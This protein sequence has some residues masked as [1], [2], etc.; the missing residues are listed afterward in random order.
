MLCHHLSF[1]SQVLKE[2]FLLPLF[3]CVVSVQ[4]NIKEKAIRKVHVVS[5]SDLRLNDVM[6][7]CWK[8]LY[9][10]DVDDYVADSSQSVSQSFSIDDS[11][12]FDESSQDLTID[13]MSSMDVFDSYKPK[14]K[15]NR[16]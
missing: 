6:K 7:K 8:R 3:R 16:K 9:S 10:D 5:D 13:S 11:C 14:I 15:R 1:S 2:H 12:S 4:G